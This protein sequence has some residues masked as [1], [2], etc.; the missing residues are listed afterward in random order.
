MIMFHGGGTS[1][2]LGGEGYSSKAYFLVLSQCN[3]MCN[4]KLEEPGAFLITSDPPNGL[5]II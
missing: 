2:F 1:I 4:K 3:S 5:D